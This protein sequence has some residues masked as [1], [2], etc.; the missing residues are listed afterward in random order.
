MLTKSQRA[1]YFGGALSAVCDLMQAH[2]ISKSIAQREFSAA[3]ERSFSLAG[4]RQSRPIPP[5]SSCAD[6]CARWH[7]DRAYVDDHGNPRPLT[8]NGK[9][10]GLERLVRRV[11]GQK[12]A[13]EVLQ[14]LISRKMLKRTSRGAWLPKA[15]I[16]APS[17]LDSAQI[18]RAAIMIGRLVRTIAHNTEKRYRGDVLFEVMTQVPRLPARE[19][20]SFKKFSKA[21]GLSFARAVDDWLEV[22]NLSPSKGRRKLT[23][24][25][26]VVAFAFHEPSF[27]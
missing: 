4:T 7:V 16:V 9:T 26:G 19:I 17:G 15:K 5:I 25:A 21:Q 1:E 24:E 3:L 11:V 2:G 23:R 22:R 12:G 14:H 18:L 8:W 27:R 10:G 13:K 20:A 6:V